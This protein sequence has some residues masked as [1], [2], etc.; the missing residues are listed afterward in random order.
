MLFFFHFPSFLFCV[1]MLHFFLNFLSYGCAVL[2]AIATACL[3]G[4]PLSSNSCIFSPITFLLEPFFNGIR[5]LLFVFSQVFPFQQMK[6]HACLFRF[7]SY[8]S[9]DFPSALKEMNQYLFCFG[10]L[11]LLRL[12]C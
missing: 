7:P 5:L 10:L 1:M 9:V 6:L 2:S 11:S 3:W 4:F 8:L 12:E